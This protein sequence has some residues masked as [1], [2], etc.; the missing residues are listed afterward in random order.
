MKIYLDVFL[1]INLG[2][3]F[4]VLMLES[5]FQRREI[6][7]RRLLSAAAVGG[8]LSALFLVSGVHRCPWLSMPLYLLGSAFIIRLAFGKT[9]P[10]AFVRNMVIFYLSAFVLAGF[11]VQLQGALGKWG[12]GALLLAGSGAA[13]AL[14]YRLVP[15]G[16]RWRERAER[17]F[18]ICLRYGGQS[19]RGNGLMDTGNQLTEP[20]SHRPV[21]IGG[22]D[23]VR[24]LL[25]EDDMPVFRYIPYHSIGE[26]QGVLPAFQAECLEVREGGKWRRQE[27][28][29]IAICD[30]YVSA[31]GEYELILHPDMLIKYE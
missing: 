29:W 4:V 20:I 27:K 16:S 21:A 10:G 8:V 9:T 28:P 3:N 22:R 12:G 11:L 2:M 23:L 31:D 7:L 19:V 14:A 6:R 18:P 24:R 1:V 26:E 30:S 5:F 15:L 17:Y 13:L 25:K